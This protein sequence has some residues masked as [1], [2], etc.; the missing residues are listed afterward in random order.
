MT[1]NT[2]GKNEAGVVGG[3]VRFGP[4]QYNPASGELWRRGRRIKLV[5]QPARL[6]N[7]LIERAGTVVMRE[8]MRSRLWPEG[9]FVDFEH[10]LNAAIK[11]L[12]RGLGDSAAKP[13]F[14][15]TMARQGYRF[16]APVEIADEISTE[17]A[18][19]REQRDT[20][21]RE[22]DASSIPSARITTFPRHDSLTVVLALVSG[23]LLSLALVRW[24]LQSRSV[25]SHSSK[26]TLLVAS[27][28]DLSSP[29]ISSDGKLLAYA[30][31]QRI[32]QRI[33][34]RRVA[35]GNPMRL[36]REEVREADPAFAP[37]DERIAF[38][39]YP[40]RP[41]RPQICTL[42][43][44]GGEPSCLLPGSREPA[45]SP[46]GRRL[47]FVLERKDGTEALATSKADG[48]LLQIILPPSSVY[49]LLH[50]PTWSADGRSI[51]VDRSADGFGAEIWIVPAE[52]GRPSVLNTVRAG[53]F[54]RHPIF[55]RDG[56][57]LVYSSNRGGATDLWYQPLE[58][59]RTEV[60][61]TRGPSPED[62]PSI[63]WSGRMVFLSAE[64]RDVLFVTDLRTGATVHLLNHSPHLWS[65]A[66]S[67]GGQDIAVSAGE[68]DGM[69]NI[70]TVALSGG[71]P[72][73]LTSGEAPQVYCRF[74]RDGQ[75][76]IYFTRTPGAARIWRVRCQGGP[77]E[78]LTPANED[79]AY[80]DLSP[81]GRTLAFARTDRG[82]TRVYLKRVGSTVEHQLVHAPSTVP[83][84]SP[85][86]D[87][88]AFSPDRGERSGVFIT[89]RDG[90][91]TKRL[92]SSGGWPVWLPDGKRLAFRTFG[93]DGAEQVETVTI[94]GRISPLY[95]S[96]FSNDNYSFDF[97]P[98][99]KFIAYTRPETFSS[100]IWLLDK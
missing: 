49:P 75:W 78:P 74:S 28:G 77:A 3:S 59:G 79:A 65:P 46:G 9:T 93:P 92:T 42:P 54:E 63:S 25:P 89:H 6:L 58:R 32:A 90:S 33:Y 7:F 47:V 24:K 36:S 64:S 2:K 19:P 76:I 20:T 18:A 35:G 50:H 100:E 17:S 73:P 11:R 12:R 83:R 67:P 39:R 52:G 30:K 99:G 13:Q 27:D 98:D 21:T 61:L 69:W 51:A 1:R 70:W 57:G 68:Y 97:S 26:L 53:V 16:I 8:E 86:G 56:K 60:Q 80:G 96:D 15:E 87:W 4:F 22:M 40:A 31:G 34:L 62:W 41:S 10:S 5:G 37:D 71:D 23:A 72:R 84:W 94:E 14:I 88:I 45:W 81:D 55:T 43:V 85:R 48:T 38:T 82:A 91:G 95:G 66:V 29:A 44:L